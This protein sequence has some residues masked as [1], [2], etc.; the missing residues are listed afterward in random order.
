[1]GLLSKDAIWQTDD[2]QFEDV[3]VPEWNGSVRLKG[4]T[5]AERDA[6]EAASV[7]QVGNTAQLNKRN[8]R[9]RLVA[10]C[11]IN[12]NGEPLFE[13]SDVI[14]L[15]QKSAK[16]LDRLFDSALRL[17]GMSPNDVD[18]LTENLEDDQSGNSTSD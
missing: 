10:L 7:K 14:H 13:P 16:A 4:L 15:G 2:R 12:E 17:N 18:K 1:M 11:A 3:Y 9:A 5:G 6:F 8:F